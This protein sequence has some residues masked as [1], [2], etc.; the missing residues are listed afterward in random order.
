MRSIVSFCASL[1]IISLL[2]VYP[3]HARIDPGTIIG[4][5]LFDKEDKEVVKDSSENGYH[6]E[7]VGNVKWVEGKY[8]GGLEF[9]G[10]AGNIVKV[11]HNEGLNLTTFT[12]TYWCKMGETGGWQIPVAKGNGASRNFD[13]QIPA[14]GGTVSI[15]FSQGAIQ[16]K[17]ASAK[18]VIT[19]EEWHHVASTYDQET[20]KIYVDGVMEG[21]GKYKGA[22]DH[23]DAP[24]TLGNM[25]DAHPMLGVLDEVGIFN[26][27]L[28]EDDINTI[29]I[30]GL[31]R[32]VGLTPVF[33][34]G[35]LATTWAR[36]KVR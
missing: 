9:P 23:V 34:A 3:I 32:T 6:G 26:E 10:V 24:L 35:K 8:G 36:I 31:E 2:F 11:P 4:I 29:M 5:W 15:F 7:F 12:I 17:G 33:P 27:A 20:L 16:F 1:M 19:D 30:S 14:G 21:S 25:Q 22:P 28:S 13:F 18:T